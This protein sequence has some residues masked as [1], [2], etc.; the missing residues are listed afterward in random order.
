MTQR[1]KTLTAG[2]LGI[3]VVFG[4]GFLFYLF[5]YEPVSAIREQLE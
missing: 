2:L 1:E 5:V 4:G 3:L